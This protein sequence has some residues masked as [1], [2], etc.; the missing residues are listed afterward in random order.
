MRKPGQKVLPIALVLV[1]VFAAWLADHLNGSSLDEGDSAFTSGLSKPRKGDE[2]YYLAPS[3]VNKSRQMLEL[4]AVGPQSADAGLEFVEARVYPKPDRMDGPVIAWSTGAGSAS[5]PPSLPSKPV[6]GQQ[7]APEST[8]EGII[9]LRYRVTSAQRPL[10]SSGVKVTYHRGF[11]DH[12][13][14]LPATYE[15]VPPMSR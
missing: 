4:V 13:Q 6:G 5:S 9:Y 7:I 1:L 3:V 14:V 15:V 8:L 12:S 2:V 10:Q 11:R